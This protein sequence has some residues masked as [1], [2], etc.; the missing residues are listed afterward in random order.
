MSYL[1]EIFMR[2]KI[3]AAGMFE[4]QQAAVAQQTAPENLADHLLAASL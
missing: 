2:R 1:P 3:L 4:D